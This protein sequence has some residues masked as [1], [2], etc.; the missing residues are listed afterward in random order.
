MRTRSE[1]ASPAASTTATEFSNPRV[2]SGKTAVNSFALRASLATPVISTFQVPASASTEPSSRT[3]VTCN[4]GF[5]PRRSPAMPAENTTCRPRTT[6]VAPCSM[7]SR[8]R[9]SSSLA[10]LPSRRAASSSPGICQCIC[11]R[12]ILTRDGAI[13]PAQGASNRA[14]LTSMLLGAITSYKNPNPTISARL[15]ASRTASLRSITPSPGTPARLL[16]A[17][18]LSDFT[19]TA[20]APSGRALTSTVLTISLWSSG[21]SRSISRAA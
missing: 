7:R 21:C 5:S 2:A 14:A 18:R 20:A 1:R 15:L 12:S 16:A 10:P 11:G 8:R 9:S 17:R 6:A 4:T 13:Q 19:T 3:G